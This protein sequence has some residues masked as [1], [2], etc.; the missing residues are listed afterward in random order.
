MKTIKRFTV[1]FLLAASF[2]LVLI[3]GLLVNASQVAHA[4]NTP[5]LTIAKQRAK[6]GQSLDVTAQG[7]GIYDTLVLTLNSDPDYTLG[8][9]GCNDTGYCAGTV[10]IP[11]NNIEEGNY[12]VV[13][14]SWDS[15]LSAQAPDLLH[16]VPGITAKVDAYVSGP[17]TEGGPGTP[18]SLTGS[19]F[20]ANEVVS[21]SWGTSPGI[22]E[23][24]STIDN[25]GNLNFAFHAPTSIAPGTYPIVVSRTQAPK[26]IQTSFKIVKPKVILPKRFFG[27]YGDNFSFSGFQSRE[28]I[29]VSWN[30]NGGQ[31]LGTFQA[32]DAGGSWEGIAIPVPFIAQGMYTVTFVGESS[33]ITLTAPLHIVPGLLLDNSDAYNAG[34]T[35]VVNGYG[36]SAHETLKVFFQDKS[37]GVFTVTTDASGD[38]T[39]SL[40]APST[41]DFQ[42]SYYV[43]AKNGADNESAKIRVPFFGPNFG[44]PGS[45][46]YG[47]TAYVSGYGFASNEVVDM[48]WN[49]QQPGQILIGSATAN[50]GGSFYSSVTIPSVPAQQG[51]V[52]YAAVGHK[53]NFVVTGTSDEKSAFF[54]TPT[55]ATSSQQIHVTAG[56]FASGETVS[57]RFNGVVLTTTTADANG[58]VDTTFMVPNLPQ[59]YYE[60]NVEGETSQIRDTNVF[61]VLSN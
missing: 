43:Y 31:L 28:M 51:S 34:S 27:P 37:N 48:Y 46:S 52:T 10:I 33:G 24:M 1:R 8:G 18:L 25:Q 13:A 38:F 32:D 39:A 23:G 54:Y 3:P 7:F 9:L 60:I 41:I 55:V 42:V 16:I 5:T 11:S 59:G 53:S 21:I 14:T 2:T 30:A 22:P 29:D 26:T 12:T 6:I 17:D 19:G 36:Y 35:I 49:Y 40:T 61:G 45:V 15:G 20:L 50:S 47:D 4:E 56:C 58:A 57:I 44:I